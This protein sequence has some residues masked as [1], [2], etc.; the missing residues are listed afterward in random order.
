MLYDRLP[1]ATGVG[2]TLGVSM[3]KCAFF[4]VN[5]LCTIRV[6]YLLIV[7]LSFAYNPNVHTSSSLIIAEIKSGKENLRYYKAFGQIHKYLIE[8]K[9]AKIRNPN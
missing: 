2:Q 4:P 1:K 5:Y 8:N 7:D 3:C 9:N 6:I